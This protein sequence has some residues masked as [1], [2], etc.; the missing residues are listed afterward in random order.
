MTLLRQPQLV[1][2][3]FVIWSDIRRNTLQETILEVQEAKLEQHA[4]MFGLHTLLFRP[5][6][7]I[8]K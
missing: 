4:C 5:Q 8:L 6:W 2:F 1:A 3:S 7:L